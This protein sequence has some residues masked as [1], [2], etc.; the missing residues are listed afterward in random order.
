MNT[1]ALL[2]PILNHV[3]HYVQTLVTDSNQVTVDTHLYDLC[4]ELITSQVDAMSWVSHY[5]LA[6]FP[7]YL[8]TYT[9]RRDRYI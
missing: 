4:Q 2:Q 6:F 1:S 5:L 9:F 7:I 3:T 8:H